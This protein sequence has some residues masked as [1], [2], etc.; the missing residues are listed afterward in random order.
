MGWSGDCSLLKSYLKFIHF[1]LVFN[2][3]QTAS[4]GCPWKRFCPS[5]WIGSMGERSCSWLKHNC[6]CWPCWMA[7]NVLPSNCFYLLVMSESC[8]DHQTAGMLVQMV[9]LW[10]VCPHSPYVNQKDNECYC[11]CGV[12]NALFLSSC[13]L[14]KCLWIRFICFLRLFCKQFKYFSFTK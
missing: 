4:L 11:S 5:A 12:I 10:S 13:K 7:M 14:F 9:L 3:N 1:P 8:G 2:E 6:C